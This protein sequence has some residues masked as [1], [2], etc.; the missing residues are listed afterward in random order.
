[1]SVKLRTKV[2]YRLNF[3]Q[4]ERKVKKASIDPL[5]RIAIKVENEAKKSLKQGGQRV[6]NNRR[7]QIP[8]EPGTPP[9]SQ[10]GQLRASIKRERKGKGFIVGPTVIYGRI[11]EFGGFVNRAFYPARPFMR[12]ALMRVKKIMH[13]E[14]SRLKI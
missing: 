11:H 5:E 9:H 3:K 14:F 10:T 12:P 1:M 8:S 13:K 2:K 7:V 6:I 4:V